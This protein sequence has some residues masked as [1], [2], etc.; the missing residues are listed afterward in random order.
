MH[1]ILED[2]FDMNVSHLN[3]LTFESE[4]KQKL[5]QQL[6]NLWLK[7]RDKMNQFG[8]TKEQEMFYFEE[9]VMLLFNWLNKLG[10]KIHSHDSKDF[11]T[12][13]KDLTPIREEKFESMERSVRGFIDAIEKIGNEVR[14]MD[15]KTSKKFEINKAYKLQLAIYAMLYQDKYG[16]MPQTVGIYFLKDR[17]KHEYCLDVDEELIKWAKEEVEVMHY[18]TRSDLMNDYPMIKTP[19]CKWSTGKCDFYEYCFKGKVV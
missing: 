2:F 1:T 5:Q 13:F 8:L 12:A 19:L 11:L 10:E 15:Y 7:N 16:E 4:L 3:L 14:V 9:T 6:L 17:G 18:N